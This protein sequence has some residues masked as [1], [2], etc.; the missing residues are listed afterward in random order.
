MQLAEQRLSEGSFRIQEPEKRL[1]GSHDL[2]ILPQCFVSR[3]LA[4]PAVGGVETFARRLQGPLRKSNRIFEKMF[5][6]EPQIP[7]VPQ[8][9]VFCLLA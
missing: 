3:L 9:S 4:C 7:K 1:I 6:L 5:C 8:H 2:H